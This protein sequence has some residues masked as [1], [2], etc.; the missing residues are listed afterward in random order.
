MSAHDE[1]EDDLEPEVTEGAEIETEKYEEA[2]DQEEIAPET[3]VTNPSE[4]EEP[5]DEAS[6][7][8]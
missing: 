2:E 4:Q 8:I 3:D 1:H 7:T 5:E 6:D